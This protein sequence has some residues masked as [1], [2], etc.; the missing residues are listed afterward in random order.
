M[1]RARPACAG[2]GLSH[3]PGANARLC[4]DGRRATCR[5]PRAIKSNALF[6]ACVPPDPPMCGTPK[7]AP[8]GGFARTCEARVTVKFPDRSY[9]LRRAA[10]PET[11]AVR[12]THPT[13]TKYGASPNYRARRSRLWAAY[14]AL[15]FL[16]YNTRARAAEVAGGKSGGSKP[17]TAGGRIPLAGVV[18]AALPT[19]KTRRLR[20]KTP[21]AKNP[22]ID[23]GGCRCSWSFEAPSERIWQS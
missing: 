4:S 17:R 1:A 5:L 14:T 20:P 2:S 10:D 22:P 8:D 21:G 13:T 15:R 11:L 16:G 12:N 18:L 19:Q 6:P 7:P 3:M 9:G 23:G